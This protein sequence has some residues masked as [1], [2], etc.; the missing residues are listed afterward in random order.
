MA[1]SFFCESSGKYTWITESMANVGA[2]EALYTATEKKLI[3]PETFKSLYKFCTIQPAAYHLGAILSQ[4]DFIKKSWVTANDI[5]NG[6]F[7]NN[8]VFP[9]ILNYFGHS[10]PL[11]KAYPNNNFTDAIIQDYEEYFLI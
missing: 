11:G 3:D 1:L 8:K 4:S 2:L 7:D 9:S 10:D 6:D 5:W